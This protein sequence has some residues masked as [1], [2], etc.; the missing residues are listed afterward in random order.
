MYLQ[1]KLGRRRAAASA[2]DLVGTG[3]CACFNLRKAARAVTRLYDSA[4]RRS[5]LRS[6]QF[7]ILVAVA[8]SERI[9]LGGLAKIL[10]TDPTTLTRNLGQMQK[11][12]LLEV[13]E[14]LIGRRRFVT[15]SGKGHRALAR[16][17][18]YW[19][20]IQRRFVRRIGEPQWRTLQAELE[21]LSGAAVRLE[22]S[23][24]DARMG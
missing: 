3:Y 19:R 9:S 10:D 20:E 8:K 14:R 15:L 11:H 23:T 22:T 12:G 4:L 24:R 6:T 21:K 7:T 5:G 17:L 1:V 13:S 16:S 2:V 18:P